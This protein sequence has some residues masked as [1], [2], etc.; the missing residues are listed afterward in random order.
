MTVTEV[1]LLVAALTGSG[2]C[3]QRRLDPSFA[4][5]QLC[6]FGV[7]ELQPHF[8]NERWIIVGLAAVPISSLIHSQLRWTC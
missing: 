4:K 1:L 5:Q 6:S 8:A 2:G 7:V 3:M